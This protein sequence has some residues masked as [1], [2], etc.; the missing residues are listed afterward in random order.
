MDNVFL[1]CLG[2]D[3]SCD[4]GNKTGSGFLCFQSTPDNSEW[5][6]S[7]L[8]NLK[9]PTQNLK[10]DSWFM[11][12]SQENRP[13]LVFCKQWPHSLRIFC[14]SF[15]AK[16]SYLQWS[17]G[18]SNPHPVL[19]GV[20][21]IRSLVPRVLVGPLKQKIRY[22]QQCDTI[23]IMTIR[24]TDTEHSLCTSIMHS[25]RHVSCRSSLTTSHEEDATS[26]GEV[27]MTALGVSNFGSSS[28]A[29]DALLHDLR[30]VPLSF[31]LQLPH[32]WNGEDNS[33]S[34]FFEGFL[35]SLTD[36]T[37]RTETLA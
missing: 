30:Q 22:S 9:S 3:G 21:I 17:L 29:L 7:F 26:W 11:S 15:Q 8:R 37:I 23:E 5:H 27:E 33:C 31:E 14:L 32:L 25:T 20:R 28:I 10:Y 35:Q 34:T 18:C 2:Q 36:A 16:P 6:K 13:S 19:V 1:E 4:L 12:L 24:V